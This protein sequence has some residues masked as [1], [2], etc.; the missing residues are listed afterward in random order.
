MAVFLKR[1]E[2]LCSSVAGIELHE[3]CLTSL[4]E[5]GSKCVSSPSSLLS[6]SAGVITLFH[7]LEHLPDPIETLIGL[8]RLLS[9]DGTLIVEVPHANDFLLNFPTLDAFKQF[10]LWSP[11]LV[12]HTRVSL[13]AILEFCGF[14]V[15]SIKGVQ[16]YPLSNHVGWLA[17]RKTGGHV[18]PLSALDPWNLTQ[19]YESSLARIDAI[20]TFVAFATLETQARGHDAF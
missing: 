15:V 6:N 8:K 1:A 9:K 4:N 12:L 10:A 18:S 5:R 20:D 2:L 17:N 13:K 19:A 7:V 11:R 14:R 16:R 3:E